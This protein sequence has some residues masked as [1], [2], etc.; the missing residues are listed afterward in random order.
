MRE[1]LSPC[2]VFAQYLSAESVVLQSFRSAS[3]RT[4]KSRVASPAGIHR[5]L[6]ARLKR[7]GFNV[8]TERT[9]KHPFAPLRHSAIGGIHQEQLRAIADLLKPRH[10]QLGVA[11]GVTAD[12]AL[13]VLGNGYA[14][15][16]PFD[17]IQ[18]VK[19]QVR[20]HLLRLTFAKV[21]F[22]APCLFPAAGDAEGRTGGEPS[23]MSRVNSSG[24]RSAVKRS[25]IGQ[26]W[27]SGGLRLRL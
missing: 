10:H 18:V 14:R 15:S 17:Q 19:K 16:Q 27:Y 7:R 20:Q 11:L 1:K 13:D 5:C 23:R 26:R 9:E 3:V 24:G 4:C 21:L 8:I 25:R 22:L 12:H 6:G 2:F